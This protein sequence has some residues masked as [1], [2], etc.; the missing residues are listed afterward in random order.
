[1]SLLK[2]PGIQ[3]LF[4]FVYHIYRQDSDSIIMNVNFSTSHRKTTDCGT[5]G[6]QLISLNHIHF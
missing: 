5:V 4:Y 3:I 1:M 6:F 2:L